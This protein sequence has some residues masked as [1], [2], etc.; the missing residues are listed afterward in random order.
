MKMIVDVYITDNFYII[1]HD[2]RGKCYILELPDFF[3]LLRGQ[4]IP[5]F[6]GELEEIIK[7]D[8][9]QG[10]KFKFWSVTDFDGLIITANTETK[11]ALIEYSHIELDDDVV[12]EE[13]LLRVYTDLDIEVEEIRKI[14]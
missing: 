14:G 12:R 11:T 10:Y 7:D 1:L 6:E 4:K 8:Y 9:L 13:P 5:I 2:K 3:K